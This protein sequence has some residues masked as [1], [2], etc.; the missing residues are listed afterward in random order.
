VS[1]GE[2]K[3]APDCGT[4][5][6]L[7]TDVTSTKGEDEKLGGSRY[8]GEETTETKE[9]DTQSQQKEGGKGESLSHSDI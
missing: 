9:T 4:L 3:E 7:Y 6:L 1:L 5:L 2:Q 8:C